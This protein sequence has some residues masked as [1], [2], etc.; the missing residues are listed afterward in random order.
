M[1]DLH[2]DNNEIQ[3]ISNNIESSDISNNIESSDI[4]N[5]ITAQ[6]IETPRSSYDI[7]NPPIVNKENIKLKMIDKALEMVNIPN[8]NQTI[9]KKIKINLIPTN[10]INL[11]FD[12]LDPIDVSDDDIEDTCTVLGKYKKVSYTQ[13]RDS[14]NKL[15]YD[16]NEYFSSA[17]D[18]LA[19]Y[20]RGQK[21]IYMES[22]YFRITAQQTN[23]S[24]YIFIFIGDGCF[25]CF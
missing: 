12:T 23:A 21:L 25:S 13:V 9:K 1:G 18:I 15:Y 20:V 8:I 2:T 24:C 10:S 22:Q 4:S 7:E 19:S 16:P 11:D 6:I 3:D 17:M 5:N 14:I